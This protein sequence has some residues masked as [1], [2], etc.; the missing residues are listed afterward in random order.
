MTPSSKSIA[1]ADAKHED[2]KT[3]N[4]RR[5][6]IFTERLFWATVALSVIA[7][8]QLFVFSWQGIQLKRTVTAAKEA[9]DLARQEFNATH[10]P[11]IRFHAAEI[12]RRVNE[13]DD[14]SR[15]EIYKVRRSSRAKC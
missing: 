9:T 4:D 1:A 3:E 13:G 2:E 15:P 12:T 5:L 8:F 10:R 14:V 7:L 6:A 11:K